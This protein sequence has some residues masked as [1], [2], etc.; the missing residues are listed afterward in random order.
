[1]DHELIPGGQ[2]VDRS[3]GTPNPAWIALDYRPAGQPSAGRS[4][5]GTRRGEITDGP[6]RN[7]A[8]DVRPVPIRQHQAPRM[9][10]RLGPL[11]GPDR[12]GAPGRR[13]LQRACSGLPSSWGVD[14]WASEPPASP[15]QT[16]R[17]GRPVRW[18]FS[19]CSF[20]TL[21]FFPPDEANPLI[22]ATWACRPRKGG[23][24]RWRSWEA[25]G[26]DG[27]E[28]QTRD[29]TI[30]SEMIILKAGGSWNPPGRRGNPP[31]CSGKLSP[32]GNA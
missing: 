2:A 4:F 19:G 15:P 30:R 29:L 6:E 14:D 26:L 9:D 3:L 28:V 16:P 24:P 13:L 23:A 17:P 5:L 31:F 32:Y 25:S 1:M 27:L 18:S 10:K 20:R 22:P 21:W 11:G 8:S 12:L 7:V